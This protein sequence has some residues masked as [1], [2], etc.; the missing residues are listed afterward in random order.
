MSRTG[1]SNAPKII[2]AEDI[3]DIAVGSSFL[4]TGGGG[5]PYIA[6]LTTE[7]ILKQ[8][9]G[10]ELL[11]LD[12]VPDD[13]LVVAIGGIGAPMVSLEKLGNGQEPLWALEALEAHVGRKAD[14]LISFEVG[15]AN[16]LIPIAA[17]AQRNLPV[18]DADGMGRALPEMQMV[19]F[20][21]Y[22]VKGTPMAVVDEFG[23]SVVINARNSSAAERLVRNVS[24]AMGGACVS[25]EHMM[26][27][28]TAKQVSVPGTLD[29]CRQVGAAIHRHRGNPSAFLQDLEGIMG[30]SIYGTTRVLS[31][32]KVVDVRRKIEGGFN[33]GEIVLEPFGDPENPVVIQFRNEYLT[34]E[35]GGRQLAMVP[36]LICAIDADTALPVT[37]ESVRFGQRMI[38]VGVGAPEIMRREQALEFVG[39][40]AFDMA[41]DFTP[42]EEIA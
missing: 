16:S 7:Q 24:Q 21:I 26:D 27:G 11:S 34:A 35:Q 10:V 9:G 17:A 13:A 23:D 2:N 12:A 31:E 4:A 6:Q 38:F 40:R 33:I 5:D 30:G 25:A 39:P 8:S 14:A 15:G 3:Q 19:T 28:A 37:A 29:L 22:G 42:L 36:D 32:G 18:I 41:F 20:S 1:I